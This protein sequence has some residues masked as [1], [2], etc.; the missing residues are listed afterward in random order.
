MCVCVCVCVN[1]VCSVR[2]S[3]CVNLGANEFEFHYK[4]VT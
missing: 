3:E 2:V 4:S 1:C